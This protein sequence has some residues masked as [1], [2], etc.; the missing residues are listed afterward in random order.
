MINSDFVRE[1]MTTE[2]DYNNVE[3]IKLITI[4]EANLKRVVNGH[5]EKGYAIISACRQDLWENNDGKIVAD[6]SKEEKKIFRKLIIGSHEHIDENNKRT[7][8]LRSKLHDKYSF[9]P[10]FGRLKEEG[11]DK[12]NIEK[13]FIVFPFNITTKEDTDFEKFVNDIFDWCANKDN[14]Q[15]VILIK[16]PGKSP[17]YYDPKTKKPTDD[18]EFTDTSLNDITKE[19]FAALKKRNDISKKD[20]FTKEN[21][22]RGTFESYMNEFPKTIAGHR[23]R[24]N[25]GELVRFEKYSE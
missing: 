14:P 15:D 22:Q 25:K 3:G 19:Y 6:V 13:G 1:A 17:R 11:Q 8:K 10:I 18:I 16:F 20:N 12:A 21:P 24:S 9:I 5:D 4:N 23:I 7:K 2:E